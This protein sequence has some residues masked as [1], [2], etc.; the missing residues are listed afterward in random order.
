MPCVPVGFN[1]G[2]SAEASAEAALFQTLPCMPVPDIPACGRAG[3]SAPFLA[4][5][6][7][8]H[9]A[10]VVVVCLLSYSSPEQNQTNTPPEA[11]TGLYTSQPAPCVLLSLLPSILCICS[12]YLLLQP[13][14]AWWQHICT[15]SLHHCH[16]ASRD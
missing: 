13:L 5:P 14:C 4:P 16:N 12:G 10:S 6:A 8:H 9:H 1:R 15:S 3:D 7:W 2:T 11:T